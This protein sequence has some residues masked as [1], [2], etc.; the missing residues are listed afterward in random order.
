MTD[1]GYEAVKAELDI[2]IKKKATC[3]LNEPIPVLVTLDNGI[4][5]KGVVYEVQPKS[6]NFPRGLVMVRAA[7]ADLG[8]PLTYIKGR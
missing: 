4:Q 2:A 1:A 8:V 7:N 5:Y 3:T 6:D